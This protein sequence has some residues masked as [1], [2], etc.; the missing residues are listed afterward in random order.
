MVVPQLLKTADVVVLFSKYEGLFLFSIKG[1]GSGKPFLASAVSG[2]IVV[3]A[4]AGILFPVGADKQLA[5]E[6]LHLANNPNHYASTA[7]KCMMR[8][9]EYDYYDNLMIILPHPVHLL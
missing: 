1:M 5:K 9:K 8:A 7:N 4:G 2:L 3:V 6:I